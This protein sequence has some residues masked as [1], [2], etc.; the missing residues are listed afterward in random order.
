M[1]L[2]R[3]QGSSVNIQMSPRLIDSQSGHGDVVK[4]EWRRRQGKCLFHP[5]QNLAI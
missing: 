3:W 1:A 2:E 5:I 4:T